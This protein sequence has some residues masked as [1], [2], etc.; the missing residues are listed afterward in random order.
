[1]NVGGGTQRGGMLLEAMVAVVILTIAFLAWSGS[2]MGASQGQYHAAKHTESIEIANYLL[3]QMRRDPQFWSEFQGPSCTQTN[4][5][6]APN[7]A[8]RDPCNV[9]YPAYA[10]AG[11][12]KNGAW[13]TGCSNLTMET[14]GTINEPYNFEWRADI[15]CKGGC[16]GGGTQDNNAADITVWVETQTLHG[17]W[18]TYVVTGLKKKPQS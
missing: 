14:G 4:C 3:E 11:P 6:S 15:H 2:M 7:P 8:E 17:G 18:D 10:D 9:N 5:W 16:S 1:V 13:H 12:Y